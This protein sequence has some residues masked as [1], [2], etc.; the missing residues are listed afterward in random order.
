M[1]SRPR[2]ERDAAERPTM[3]A[4]ALGAD[5]LAE[6]QAVLVQAE[7]VLGETSVPPLED[8]DDFGAAVAALERGWRDVRTAVADADVRADDLDH[9]N[10]E[11]LMRR[12]VRAERTVRTA[13]V[14]RRESA[15]RLV[16]EALAEL[17]DIGSVEGLIA[18]GGEALCRL[19]FDRGL[20]SSVSD[21]V[22]LTESLHL[23]DDPEWA[24]SIVA[25]GRANPVVLGRG[26]P[27]DEARRR[28]RPVLVTGVQE[29]EEVHQAVA[30]A[31]QA[32]SYAAA[33]IMPGQRL[34]GFVHGDRFFH[35]GD[36]TDFD[37]E[38]VGV[39]TQGYSFALERAILG[40]ELARL[41]E[42][43]RL[44]GAGLQDLGP[45]SGSGPDLASLRR[46]EPGHPWTPPPARTLRS[47][48]RTTAYDATLTRRE[49]EVLE[50]MAQGDT[51]QRIA[52]R[53]SITEGTA[54]SH[55]KHIL[56]KLG[57]ANR[58]EAVA[59]WHQARSDVGRSG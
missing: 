20:I 29:R 6:L 13:D 15:V 48:P 36:L 50:L 3:L 37:A 32:R 10:V 34:L 1:S 49:Q 16:R 45:G 42:T 46:P 47:V 40:E 41:Q 38:L 44:I 28:R 23:D 9:T 4:E 30:E 35:R 2:P 8:I 7:R 54:K 18:H 22:W 43:V 52:R 19:G 21:D 39:F 51:N 26:L 57:A 53:L 12:I 58:A 56:R 17:R 59:R 31:S 24:A 25:A 27:E 14:R 11:D 5:Q 33:P 55:V